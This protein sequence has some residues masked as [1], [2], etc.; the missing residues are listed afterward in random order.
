MRL[1][2]SELSTQ[3]PEDIDSLRIMEWLPCAVLLLSLALAV[4]SQLRRSFKG[5]FSLPPDASNTIV[6]LSVAVVKEVATAIF[7]TKIKDGGID[8]C[9]PRAGQGQ[10][11]RRRARKQGR[12]GKAVLVPMPRQQFTAS[13]VGRPALGTAADSLDPPESC[14]T[15]Q[16]TSDIEATMGNKDAWRS[17][18]L[19]EMQDLPDSE[20]SDSEAQ[21]LPA[22]R[23]EGHGEAQVVAPASKTQPCSKLDKQAACAAQIEVSQVVLNEASDPKDNLA[24]SLLPKVAADQ[25]TA[26]ASAGENVWGNEVERQYSLLLLLAHRELNIRTLTR[27]PPGLTFPAQGEALKPH[28]PVWGCV[29]SR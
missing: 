15:E 1:R 2:A 13:A 28:A 7:G 17:Q 16:E 29:Q 25:E 18:G 6:M 19:R 22:P 23:A 3:Q 27:G 4:R 26:E 12:T 5:K 9:R 20:S 11:A 21:L 8:D 14:M 24:T 10:R